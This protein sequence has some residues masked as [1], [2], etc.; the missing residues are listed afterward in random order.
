MFHDTAILRF[1][2]KPTYNICCSYIGIKLQFSVHRKHFFNGKTIARITKPFHMEWEWIRLF[3][4]N[5]YT[6]IGKPT[7]WFGRS[8][9][10]KICVF[11]RLSKNLD[12]VFELGSIKIWKMVITY[13]YLRDVMTSI[14]W[15]LCQI[16]IFSLC[17]KGK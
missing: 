12:A 2:L 17:I 14:S 5:R 15:Y 1:S 16:S 11:V 10:W 13:V 7:G 3:I 4:W 8:S 6:N 9:V